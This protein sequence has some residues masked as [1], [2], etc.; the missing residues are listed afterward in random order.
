M[1]EKIECYEP[2]VRQNSMR[3]IMFFYNIVFL[4]LMCILYKVWMHEDAQ[5]KADPGDDTDTCHR[6]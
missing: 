5:F 4:F 2:A 6:F 3:E 1:N